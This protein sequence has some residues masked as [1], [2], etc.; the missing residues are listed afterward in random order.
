MQARQL[1]IIVT[2]KDDQN[3]GK[4]ECKTCKGTHV[5]KDPSAA[6]AKKVSR[7]KAGAKTAKKIAVSDLWMEALNNTSAKSRPYS[8]REKFE[9]GDIV[10][11]PKFAQVIEKLLDAD[12]IQVIFQHDVKTLIHNR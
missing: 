6:K 1:H 12:K 3:I 11:H 10:D 4:V 7:K 2:M 5:Y 8:V 9:I